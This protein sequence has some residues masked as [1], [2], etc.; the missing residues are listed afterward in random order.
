MANITRELQDIRVGRY[1]VDIRFPIHDALEKL[2]NETPA[3]DPD[4]PWYII[5][6]EG[7]FVTTNTDEDYVIAY[8]RDMYYLVTNLNEY[9]V[10]STEEDY[11][12]ARE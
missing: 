11:C 1:G 8:G 12:Q 7:D 9:I 6:S 5:T 3:I 4:G 2:A 10:S